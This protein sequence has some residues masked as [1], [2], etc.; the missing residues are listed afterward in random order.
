MFYLRKIKTDV[1]DIYGHFVFMYLRSSKE[2]VTRYT[3]VEEQNTN[4]KLTL[5]GRLLFYTNAII[6]FTQSFVKRVRFVLCIK[7]LEINI[8]RN[9]KQYRRR[10]RNTNKTL[11]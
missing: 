4:D 8:R 3:S 9:L 10:D 11:T 6:S 2:G 1:I 7:I 5:Q